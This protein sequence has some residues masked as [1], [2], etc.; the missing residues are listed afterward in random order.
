MEN[1]CNE[2]IVTTMCSSLCEK[3][4][5]YVYNEG[6]VDEITKIV[7]NRNMTEQP[8]PNWAARL[9]M[10]SEHHDKKMFQIRIRDSK[11]IQFEM[12][13]YIDNL[14][15]GRIIWQRERG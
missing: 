8:G 4:F 7:I 11:L 14:N 3:I 6:T 15:E 12:M 1:T 13:E 2:C 9:V 5:D 10:E